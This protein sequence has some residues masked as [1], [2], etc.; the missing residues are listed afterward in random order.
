MSDLNEN[1]ISKP[2]TEPIVNPTFKKAS[3]KDKIYSF[4][5]IGSKTT[6]KI[7]RFPRQTFPYSRTSNRVDNRKTNILTFIPILLLNEFK[8]FL[9]LYFLILCLSQFVPALQ[10]GKPHFFQ[11]NFRLFDQ[12]HYSSC[13]Y[14]DYQIF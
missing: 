12:L 14:S 4:F 7:T 5:G 10:V 1:L 13:G 9:N 11:I 3:L 8:Q 6:Y 2:S